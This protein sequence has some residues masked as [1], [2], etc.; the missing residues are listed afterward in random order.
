VHEKLYT[1][2][3]VERVDLG[4]YL[5]ELGASLLRLHAGEATGVRLRTEVESL[6][7]RWTRRCRSA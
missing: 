3:E 2:G 6:V 4:T 5:G 1:A 7:V